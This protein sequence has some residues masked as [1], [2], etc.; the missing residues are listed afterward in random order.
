MLDYKIASLWTTSGECS[1]RIAIKWHSLVLKSPPWNTSQPLVSK[2]R[3]T[4]VLQT[5]AR[6]IETYSTAHRSLHVGE[7]TLS[8]VIWRNSENQ[9]NIHTISLG[10]Y[11]HQDELMV[12]IV[13]TWPK[14]RPK[15]R[16]P[17]RSP[18]YYGGFGSTECNVRYL[19]LQN[20]WTLIPKL[21]F[22]Y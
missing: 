12:G 3:A 11:T 22:E 16:K 6:N 7:V 19:W 2:I 10:G 17:Q 4:H 5:V 1:V 13:R 14:R 20:I 15:K 9:I 18:S 8:R 21:V